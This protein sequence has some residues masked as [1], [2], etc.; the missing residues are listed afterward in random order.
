MIQR[1]EEY[2][3]AKSELEDTIDDFEKSV[4]QEAGEDVLEGNHVIEEVDLEEEQLEEP[5]TEVDAG[6]DLKN[7]PLEDPETNVDQRADFE[8]QEVKEPGLVM[9]EETVR[10]DEP[11]ELEETE[12]KVEGGA[13]LDSEPPREPETKIIETTEPSEVQN[14]IAELPNDSF[15][16]LADEPA[17]DEPSLTVADDTVIEE[18]LPAPIIIEEESASNGSASP[19]PVAEEVAPE[20][21]PF[22]DKV[23]KLESMIKAFPLKIPRPSDESEIEVDNLVVENITAEVPPVHMTEIKG[24]EAVAPV[25][26]EKGADDIHDVPPPLRR[27]EDQEVGADISNL[28]DVLAESMEHIPAPI[29]DTDETPLVEGEEV[30]P[31]V[32]ELTAELSEAPKNRT[33]EETNTVPVEMLVAPSEAEKSAVEAEEQ[34]EQQHIEISKPS[35]T[36]E[37]VVKERFSEVAPPAEAVKVDPEDDL[38]IED[39]EVIKEAETEEEG[40]L[41]EH[42]LSESEEVVMKPDKTPLPNSSTLN[43]VPR[44][45]SFEAEKSEEEIERPARTNKRSLNSSGHTSDSD[46]STASEKGQQNFY[47]KEIIRRLVLSLPFKK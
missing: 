13:N 41:A 26:N 6:A 11:L 23:Q 34:P 24:V 43:M 37:V 35:E 32:E 18:A 47:L 27:E 21:V 17:G 42:P 22:A 15:E 33:T 39:L 19:P 28:E 38:E 20:T 1:M 45:Y 25:S 10:K 7:E 44:R 14:S 8:K 5:E 30:K 46:R 16:T 31:A 40:A 12:T 3:R 36:E 9:E 2:M 29:Q 4:V